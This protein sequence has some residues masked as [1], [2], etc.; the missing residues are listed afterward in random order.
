MLQ[1]IDEEFK[2]REM[3]LGGY[4]YY[5]ERRLKDLGLAGAQGEKLPWIGEV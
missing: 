4:E 3:E 5:Q 1:Q 2:E